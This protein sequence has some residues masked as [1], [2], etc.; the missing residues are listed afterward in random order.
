MP[1]SSPA[2]INTVFPHPV[3]DEILKR[4]KDKAQLATQLGIEVDPLYEPAVV[5]AAN[6]V[7]AFLA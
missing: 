6:R 3:F 7:Y 1:N 2:T 4:D 5:L